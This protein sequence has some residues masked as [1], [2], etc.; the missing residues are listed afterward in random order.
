MQWRAAHEGPILDFPRCG[1]CG[2]Q[3]LGDHE[4]SLQE[5]PSHMV[6]SDS[7]YQAPPEDRIRLKCRRPSARF[8]LTSGTVKRA[9]PLTQCGECLSLIAAELLGFSLVLQPACDRPQPAFQ[10]LPSTRRLS[11]GRPTVRKLAFSKYS[12]SIFICTW[13]TTP[14]VGF[15]R[16]TR[17]R[18]FHQPLMIAHTFLAHFDDPFCEALASR[19]GLS[20]ARKWT[21]RFLESIPSRVK[22]RSQNCDRLWIK[23]AVLLKERNNRH[24]PSPSWRHLAGK[25]ERHR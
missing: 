7:R 6:R 19:H 1:A 18:I 23:G 13:R 12:A 4:Q 24:R 21:A 10:G 22:C 15:C 8:C 2:R 11:P 5:R 17:E 3:W 25:D 20:V 14:Q 9:K 16:S